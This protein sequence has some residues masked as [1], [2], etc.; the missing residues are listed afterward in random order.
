[1]TTLNLAA[2]ITYRRMTDSDLPAAHRLSQAVRWPHRLEDWQLVH[3]LGSGFVAERDG[4][5]IGTAMC[6][7]QGS[8]Y[9]SLGLIIVSPEAQGKGIGRTLMQ[10]ALDEIGDRNCLL[11]ATPAGQPLYEKLGF[12]AVG[13]VHQHQGTVVQPEVVAPPTGERIRPLGNND[14]A[15]LIELAAESTGMSRATIMNELLQVAECVVIDSYGELVGFALIRRFGHGYTIGPVVAPDPERA[16]AMISYWVGARVDSFVRIDV[17][18]SGGLSP[19]LNEL[20]LVKVDT[21]VAMVRGEPAHV[22][23]GMKQFAIIN[24]ALG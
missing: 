10:Q 13:E 8:Y 7:S 20:G 6:W 11:Y 23:P 1:M 19:W 5:I 2:E 4:E 3:R 24:Q 16:K 12:K 22:G 21:V 17:Q 15:R 9:A 18:D 14:R